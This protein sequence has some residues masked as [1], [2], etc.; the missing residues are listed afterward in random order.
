M[1]SHL[2]Q[3]VFELIPY[4]GRPSVSVSQALG[5]EAGA[6]QRTFPFTDAGGRH[7]PTQHQRNAGRKRFP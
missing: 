2:A 7:H 4:L 5:L 1:G 3:V 6:A